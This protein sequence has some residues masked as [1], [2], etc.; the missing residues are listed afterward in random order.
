MKAPSL[1]TPIRDHRHCYRP[2]GTVVPPWA[3][4]WRVPSLAHAVTVKV[5]WP[6]VNPPFTNVKHSRSTV[7]HAFL[8]CLLSVIRAGGP[9][10]SLIFFNHQKVTISF[11]NIIFYREKSELLAFFFLQNQLEKSLFLTSE[12]WIFREY[13]WI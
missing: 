5:E 10:A 4:L 1:W 3:S 7:V 8:S 2:I 9:A 13:T 11:C 12:K 6:L